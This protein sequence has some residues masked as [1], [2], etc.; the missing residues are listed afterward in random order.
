MSICKYIVKVIISPAAD[1][2]RRNCNRSFSF[3]PV[4]KVLS[5]MFARKSLAEFRH[6]QMT[7]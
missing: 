1:I 2:K 3:Q 5:W 6:P 4:E 7:E